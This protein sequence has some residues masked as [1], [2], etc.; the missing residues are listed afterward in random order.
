MTA[1]VIILPIVTRPGFGDPSW[2][3]QH[4]REIEALQLVGEAP[5]PRTRPLLVVSNQKFRVVRG[6]VIALA[7][8][9]KRFDHAM[10]A[11][12]ECFSDDVQP[13]QR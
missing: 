1:P 13:S 5:P 3:E 8:G 6:E 2:R 12:R 7:D 4:R 11:L 10:S 9:I